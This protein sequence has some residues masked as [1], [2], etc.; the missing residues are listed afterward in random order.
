MHTDPLALFTAA[1]DA[2]ERQ[3]WR[4]VANLCDSASLAEFRVELVDLVSHRPTPDQSFRT[5]DLMRTDPSMPRAV[6]EWQARR[7]REH[8]DPDLRLREEMPGV[9]SRTQLVSMSAAAVFAARL[10][11]HAIGN[12]VE[13]AWERRQ[14]TRAAIDQILASD[15]PKMRY[16]ALGW[17]PD[18]EAIRYVVYRQEVTGSRAQAAMIRRQSDGGWLFVASRDLLMIDPTAAFRT[19]FTPK[20]DLD[21]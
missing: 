15:R 10:A 14:I 20:P 9:E 13:R 8:H 1:A 4:A 21:N 17:V 6:A 16:V 2:I 18:G 12:I 7:V 19:E 11:G 3:D 5:I